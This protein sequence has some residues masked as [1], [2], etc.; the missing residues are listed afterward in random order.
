MTPVIPV[1]PVAMGGPM[2]PRTD[3]PVGSGSRA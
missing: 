3:D 1:T 2:T